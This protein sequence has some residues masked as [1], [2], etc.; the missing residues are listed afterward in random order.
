MTCRY[1]FV[2]EYYHTLT[3]A[4]HRCPHNLSDCQR[5]HCV[6]GDGM[7]RGLM[8]VNRMLPGPSVHVST[9]IVNPFPAR[10]TSY[11]VH[12]EAFPTCP[13]D[14]ML[15]LRLFVYARVCVLVYVCMCA[16]AAW[17]F[18]AREYLDCRMTSMAKHLPL[19]KKN[20]K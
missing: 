13:K 14:V 17:A 3:K 15:K 6:A 19:A 1:K 20:K 8:A 10:V 9:L 2:V 11:D 4:C 5:P 16:F 12:G 7:R 18:R